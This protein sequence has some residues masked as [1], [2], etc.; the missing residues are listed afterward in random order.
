[1]TGAV[2]VKNT[3][4]IFGCCLAAAIAFLA[5]PLRAGELTLA[6]DG[7]TAYQVAGPEQPSPMEAD[8]VADLIKLLHEITGADFAD[9]SGKTRK[10]HVGV[11]APSDK[12][13]LKENERRIATEGGNLYLYGEGKRG[14]V[15]AVYDFLRDVLGCRWY[16]VTG[17]RKIPRHKKL[18]V[19]EFRRS[20]VPSIPYITAD[21]VATLPAWRDFAR[22]NAQIGRAHV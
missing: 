20:V 2:I 16:N 10:I 1:M 14:N 5:F 6:D 21:R 4:G 9:G 12:V 3:N 13:P 22:R 11:P 8:A 7:V 18:V 17:D 15:N 19:E